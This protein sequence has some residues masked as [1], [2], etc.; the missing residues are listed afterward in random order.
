MEKQ[1]F[2][3]KLQ[4]L[5][6]QCD[7][8]LTHAD[9]SWIV[10]GFI[11]SFKAVYAM[12]GDTKVLSKVVEVMLFP[13]FAKFAADNQLKMYLS[14]KQNHYPDLT[15]ESTNGKKYA[16]D[17]KTTYR[18][19]DSTVNTMT[20]GAFTGYFR[21]R[22]SNK[23]T[24]F[25]YG[26]YESHFVFCVIYNRCD[27]IPPEDRKFDLQELEAIPSVIR[28]LK[29]FAQFKYKVAKDQPG[30][31]NTKNIGAINRIED[32]IAGDGPFSKLSAEVFDDYWMYYLTKDMAR[33]AEL[34]HPP[35]KNL[36][37]YLEYKKTPKK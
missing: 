30:S 1:E 13:T 35:Y 8:L 11:D 36:K 27:D 7:G 9:G 23:N 26:E 19:S 3:T 2:L 20:L 16:V 24:L 18:E 33:A 17:L 34:A 15:F 37:T 29:F 21:D 28:D 6:E 31:G 22:K 25:P 32:L 4:A 14:G 5:A 12:P 10:K